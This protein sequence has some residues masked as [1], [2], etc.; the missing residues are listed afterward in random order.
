ML[1]EE[2]TGS[3]ADKQ[4]QYIGALCSSSCYFIC[5]QFLNRSIARTA[6]VVDTLAAFGL[7][8]VFVK[9]FVG[10]LAEVK[11]A[12]LVLVQDR[13]GFHKILIFVVIAAASILVLLLVTGE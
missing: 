2:E 5:A 13:R 3:E 10:V 8:Y 12:G 7:A 4:L 1:H 6:N 11:H 9:F